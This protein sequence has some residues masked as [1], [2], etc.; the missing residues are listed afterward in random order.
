MD[1]P[2]EVSSSSHPSALMGRLRARIYR[3]GVGVLEGTEWTAGLRDWSGWGKQSKEKDHVS[4][5]TS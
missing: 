3:P 2:A 4:Y 1:R 5:L